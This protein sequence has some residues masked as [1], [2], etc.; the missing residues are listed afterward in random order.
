MTKF[1]DFGSSNTENAEPVA[2]KLCD[3]EFQCR[4]SIPGKLILNLAAASTNQDDPATN[5][6]MIDDFFCAVLKTESYERFEKL[7]LDPDKAVEMATL[8]D[9]VQWLVETYSDRPTQ[10]PEDSSTGQ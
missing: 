9:I 1:R 7:T 10:R 8:M 4:P 5:A 3:E 6:K 2:F